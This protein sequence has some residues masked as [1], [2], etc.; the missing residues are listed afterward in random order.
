ML[1]KSVEVDDLKVIKGISFPRDEKF[2]QIIITGPPCRGKTTLIDALGGWPQEGY[3]DLA[4]KSW[5]RS[6]IFTY[7]PR[8][9]H[10]GIPFQGFKQS[11]A[12]F[13]EQWMK[14]PS[15]ID[16]E[17]IW[18]P[19]KKLWILQTDW[20]GKYV[21]DFQLIPPNLI[22]N[23]LVTR[24]KRGTHPG[25]VLLTEELVE[26]QVAIYSAIAKYFHQ[27]GL[28]VYVRRTFAGHPWRIVNH[29]PGVNQNAQMSSL[30]QR[31]ISGSHT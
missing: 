10:F 18:I 30:A 7:R 16:F 27:S 24:T 12:V 19:P 6:A 4:Q 21:F 8:E 26:R 9:I 23:V 13:D 28:R 5:W 3:V 22:Y 11:H 31:R 20:R 17:R 15:E 29:Q 25:D 2:R 1:L 14:A